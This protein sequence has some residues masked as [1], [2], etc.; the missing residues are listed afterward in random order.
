MCNSPFN[1]YIIRN[2]N[3]ECTPNLQKNEWKMCIMKKLRMDF[4]LFSTKILEFHF[5]QP[6]QS[7]FLGTN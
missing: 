3:Y 4:Q 2:R 1:F 5:L 6:F 7:L